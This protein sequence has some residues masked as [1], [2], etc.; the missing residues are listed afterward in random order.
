MTYILAEL[1][2]PGAALSRSLLEFLGIDAG[3]LEFYFHLLQK[4]IDDKVY[5]SLV[6]TMEPAS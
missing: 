3:K 6:Q 1:L 4:T 5:A 2:R